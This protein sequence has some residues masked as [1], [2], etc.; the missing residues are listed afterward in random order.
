MEGGKL[1]LEEHPKEMEVERARE[2]TKAEEA[3]L[4]LKGQAKEGGQDNASIFG[5]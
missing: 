5:I 2:Q 1:W 3:V 4:Q